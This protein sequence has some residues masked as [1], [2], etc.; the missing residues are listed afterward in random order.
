MTYSDHITNHSQIKLEMSN[1]INY[2][3]PTTTITIICL[4]PM[5]YT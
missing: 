3:I 1:I 5:E 2:P 4:E